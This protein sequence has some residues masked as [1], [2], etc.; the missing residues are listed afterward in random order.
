MYDLI[1]ENFAK[2]GL[3][4]IDYQPSDPNIGISVGWLIYENQ[5]GIQYEIDADYLEFCDSKQEVIN[6]SKIYNENR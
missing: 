3:E 5:L 2:W 4:I 1:K 6:Y